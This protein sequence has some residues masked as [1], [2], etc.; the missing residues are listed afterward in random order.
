MAE[1]GSLGRPFSEP[2]GGDNTSPGMTYDRVPT[3]GTPSATPVGWVRVVVIHGQK[4]IRTDRDDIKGD[5]LGALPE[6]AS[7][8]SSVSTLPSSESKA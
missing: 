2:H 1:G 7:G 3:S 4:F 5:N 8:G 6:Y